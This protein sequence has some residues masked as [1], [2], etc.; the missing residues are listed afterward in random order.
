MRIVPVP[1]NQADHR[2]TPVIGLF[3]CFLP[4]H[5]RGDTG[6]PI[7]IE[8]QVKKVDGKYKGTGFTKFNGLPP[9]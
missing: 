5:P 2:F 1:R 4:P 8:E 7:K 6:V 9:E 3:E